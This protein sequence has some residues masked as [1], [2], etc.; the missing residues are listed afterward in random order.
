MEKST[1]LAKAGRGTAPNGQANGPIGSANTHADANTALA[2]TMKRSLSTSS[3]GSAVSNDS[4]NSVSSSVSALR[5]K[6]QGLSTDEGPV[7]GKPSIGKRPP[8]LL[9]NQSNAPPVIPARAE[10]KVVDAEPKSFI[11]Q[12]KLSLPLDRAQEVPPPPPSRPSI[13]PKT[14]IQSYTAPSLPSRPARD[15]PP[16]PPARPAAHPPLPSR[17]APQAVMPPGAQMA[18]ADPPVPIPPRPAPR[19]PVAKEETNEKG[20]VSG[21]GPFASMMGGAKSLM[22]RSMTVGANKT[23]EPASKEKAKNTLAPPSP[24]AIVRYV[25]LF[26]E[27]LPPGRTHLN[28][29]EARAVWVK[30][31]LNSLT[32]GIIWKLADMDGDNQLDCKEFCVGMH[33]ID[34]R[35]RGAELPSVSQCMSMAKL[36]GAI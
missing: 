11:P 8:L 27:T 29:S 1:L 35:L 28:G 19:P 14:P 32:L 17:P 3:M 5:N 36:M 30:S 18:T 4:C 25:S 23:S 34:E 13:A 12:R 10:P 22:S 7:G 21:G 20:N 33:L 16:P 2:E 6:F 26:R 31:G 15:T 9:S 24:V